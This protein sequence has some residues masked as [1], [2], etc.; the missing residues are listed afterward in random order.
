[1]KYDLTNTTF[2]VPFR[3]DSESR[4]QNL[5]ITTRYINK[6]FNTK[7]LIVESDSTQK[8]FSNELYEVHFIQADPSNFHRTAL[9][10]YGFKQ[11][12]TE[13][14][15]NYDIDVLFKPEAYVAAVEQLVHPHIMFSFPY[16]GLFMDVQEEQKREID[17]LLSLE[18]VTE[19]RSSWCHHFSLGGAFFANKERYASIGFEN[20]NFIGWGLEDDE[21]VHRAQKL[22]YSISRIEGTL[23]HLPHDRTGVF[24][25]AGA[26]NHAEMF[27]IQGMDPHT[28]RE[29]IKKW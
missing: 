9:L 18:T 13:N 25:S 8:I 11:A 16:G 28:L 26:N 1:M 23:W 19:A 24:Y 2:V 12:E 22:G 29:Y 17:E 15:A 14:I 3:A 21:R 10:N 6:Y 20:P 7:I 27:K 4:L 5:D